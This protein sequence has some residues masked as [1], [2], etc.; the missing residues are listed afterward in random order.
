MSTGVDTPLASGSDVNAVL[1]VFI[2]QNVVD[3]VLTVRQHKATADNEEVKKE[4]RK[5]FHRWSDAGSDAAQAENEL[6]ECDSSHF[7]SCPPHPHPHHPH[8][9]PTRPAEMHKQRRPSLA[10]P[11]ASVTAAGISS[12]SLKPAL[13]GA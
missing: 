3:A 1:C 2:R 5:G 10:D 12:A 8:P 9:N 11:P 4:K 6:K 13:M 7:F